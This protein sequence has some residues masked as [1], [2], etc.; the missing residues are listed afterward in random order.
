MPECL[1]CKSYT[2]YRN[3]YCSSCFKERKQKLSVSK[4]ESEESRG[5]YPSHTEF[6]RDLHKIENALVLFLF[7]HY[8]I[9][10]YQTKGIFTKR[11]I[12]REFSIKLEEGLCSILLF[13]TKLM[14]FSL[15]I[16]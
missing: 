16:N 12:P 8:T 7:H 5:R 15:S 3:G 2:K 10:A 4:N 13:L 6:Y 9:N 14:P 11:F 1:N